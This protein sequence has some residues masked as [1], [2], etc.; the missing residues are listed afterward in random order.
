MFIRKIYISDR[1]LGWF[2]WARGFE[3]EGGQ[4]PASLTSSGPIFCG[5]RQRESYLEI[6]KNF[7]HCFPNE[8]RRAK[9]SWTNPSLPLN[10]PRFQEEIIDIHVQGWIL[11][12]H[13]SNRQSKS[14]DFRDFH[15]CCCGQTIYRKVWY[16]SPW[17]KYRIPSCLA[18]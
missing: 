3:K 8:S 14:Y 12:K 10:R 7:S 16:Q 5:N 2:K 18:L 17:R 6:V 1:R 9:Q 11:M 13:L 15:D 4:E